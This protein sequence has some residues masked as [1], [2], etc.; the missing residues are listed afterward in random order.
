M[1]GDKPRGRLRAKQPPPKPRVVHQHPDDP[2]LEGTHLPLRKPQPLVVRDGVDGFVEEGHP[3][4][5]GAE[6]PNPDGAGVGVVVSPELEAGD[7]GNG[8][9]TA[10]DLQ[11]LQS[12]PGV[13]RTTIPR[14]RPQGPQNDGPE[15][16]PFCLCSYN[17]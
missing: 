2:L 16:T 11:L 13:V 5:P 8:V 17:D 14:D 7:D 12:T 9:E 10:T 6:G 1:A 15:G 3:A 4:V